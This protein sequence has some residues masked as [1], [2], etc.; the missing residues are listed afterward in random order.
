MKPSEIMEAYSFEKNVH[1]HGTGKDIIVFP[2]YISDTVVVLHYYDIERKVRSKLDLYP[3]YHTD[4]VE[5]LSEHFEIE[6]VYYD[7]D[8]TPKE[9]C[10]MRQ[11]LVRKK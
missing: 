7:F 9:K 2:A 6:Q 11:Y 8:T 1:Y 3:V 4:I 10:M 5:T